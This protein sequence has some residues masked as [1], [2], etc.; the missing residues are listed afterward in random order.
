MSSDRIRTHF[1]RSVK[2]MSLRPAVGRKTAVSTTRLGENLAC[3]ITEGR[4]T[5]VADLSEKGGGEGKGPDPGVLGRAALGSCLAM[6]VKIWAAY[7]GVSVSAV[8]VTVEADFDAGAQYGV[9]DSPPGYTE[10]RYSIRVESPAPEADVMD[11]IKTAE[12]CSPWL[13]VFA[14]AQVTR[15]DARVEAP[16][17]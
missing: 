1:E 2:A 14:R 9:G 6:G 12:R 5:L 10:V 11:V 4:W 3:E 13:D 15:R 17:E 16:G 7:K 8:D